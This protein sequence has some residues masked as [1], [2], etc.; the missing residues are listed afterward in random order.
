MP[1]APLEEPDRSNT[2]EGMLQRWK[3]LSLPLL[4]LAHHDRPPFSSQPS[5]TGHCGH[6]WTCSLPRPIAIDTRQ[7]QDGT[8][9]KGLH[10]PR[11]SAIIPILTAAGS[12]PDCRAI[13]IA[14]IKISR[15]LPSFR[16]DLLVD[17]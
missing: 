14:L 7:P 2:F 16:I 5:L 1:A 8:V 6:G 9:E 12:H 4:L 10:R 11:L 15:T 3:V 13:T 17:L